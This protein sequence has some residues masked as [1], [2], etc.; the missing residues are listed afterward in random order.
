MRVCIIVPFYQ[1]EPYMER[2]VRSV[3]EQTYPDI[4]Y[5][6]IDDCSTDRSLS[7]L[8]QTLEEYPQRRD[9][10]RILHNERNLGLASCRN[11][12]IDE[13]RD[14]FLFWVDADDWVSP[15]AVQQL[16]GLQETTNA[17]IVSGRVM[18]V[19]ADGMNEKI[20]SG[21]SRLET[22]DGIMDQISDS[23]A[24]VVWGRLIRT[25]LYRDHGI[26][27][28]DGVNYW[29]DFQVLPKLLWYASS[30][31]NL[32]AVVYYYNRINPH[33]YMRFAISDMHRK[34]E[35]DK[36]RLESTK[37]IQSFFRK[38]DSQF[39][40]VNE[41]VVV[42]FLREVIRDAL[43]LG[44]RT[45]FLKAMLELKDC[46]KDIAGEFAPRLYSWAHL[47]PSVCW[48]LKRIRF[49]CVGE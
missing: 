25:A 39:D 26:R 20:I 7:I 1:D 37:S 8:E 32:D 10:I 48:I 29:E 11:L 35:K 23:I 27:C 46:E 18:N 22:L 9:A 28:L 24:H 21:S 5:L 14:E 42:F 33:S 4:D 13:C 17:D 19:D 49:I 2:C 12:A 43:M 44:D 6:F 38:M 47:S 31:A 40:I 30:V 41:R 15:D 3:M 34:M 16:V 36:Q 45:S